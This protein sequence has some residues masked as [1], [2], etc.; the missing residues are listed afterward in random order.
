MK[1]ET[2][3]AAEAV[4]FAVEGWW[5]KARAMSFGLQATDL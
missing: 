5:P 1:L 2:L 4:S 3:P